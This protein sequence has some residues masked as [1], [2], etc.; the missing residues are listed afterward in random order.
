VFAPPC[1]LVWEIAPRL[2]ELALGVD[3]GWEAAAALVRH[4]V[5]LLLSRLQVADAE[6]LAVAVV[7]GVR[8]LRGGQELGHQELHVGHLEGIRTECRCDG[9][10]NALRA[11]DGVDHLRQQRALERHLVRVGDPLSLMHRR[12]GERRTETR[13]QQLQ[14]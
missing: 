7:V 2:A 1:D 11:T 13:R 10:P 3:A 9:A 14:G 6:E 5:R 12:L 8:D 4:R